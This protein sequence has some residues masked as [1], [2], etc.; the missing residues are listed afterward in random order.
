MRIVPLSCGE[1]AA[2]PPRPGAASG[3]F[4]RN[5][6]GVKPKGWLYPAVL[7]FLVATQLLLPKAAQV[8]ERP[9]FVTYSQ[10]M[11]EPGNLELETFNVAGNPRGGNAFIGSDIEAEYGM[12][13]WWTTEFYLDGQAT[14][15]DSAIFTG[16][17][18][19][20]RFRPWLGEHHVNPVLYAE[21]EDTSADK[22]LREVVGHDGAPDFLDPNGVSRLDKEREME[23]KLILGSDVRGWNFSE[24]FITEKNL[25]SGEPWEFGYAVGVSRPLQLAANAHECVLCR[26]KFAA[27]AEIYGGLGTSDGFGTRQTS[28]YAGPTVN[29]TAPNGMTIGMSPQFGL[30]NYSVPFLFRFSVSYEIQEVFA[31]FHK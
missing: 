26:E 10:D 31:H 12:K 30:N 19:E 17:R 14:A 7:S 5:A 15:N 16:F 18:W 11:E 2:A 13:T 6:P 23:L 21:F 20:N 1:I 8:Q 4:R 24:N 27:G 29:W 25:Q 3:N 9:Y 22:T 28:H